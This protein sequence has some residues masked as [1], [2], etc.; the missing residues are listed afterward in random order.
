MDI[1]TYMMILF[2]AAMAIW[3]AVCVAVWVWDKLRK[4]EPE[5]V[6]EPDAIQRSLDCIARDME[7][8]EENGK[9]A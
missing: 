8:R 1:V 6:P 5:K 9:S 3:Q 2:V 7:R 4:P